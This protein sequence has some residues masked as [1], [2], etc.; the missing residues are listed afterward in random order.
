MT[1]NKF[2]EYLGPFTLAKLAEIADAKII[3]CSAEEAE[4]VQIEN[5]KSI[6]QASENDIS[7]ITNKKYLKEIG[8]SKA[9]AIIAPNE[10]V[11]R[12][13]EGRIFLVSDD[14][15]YTYATMLSAFYKEPEI[16]KEI[17]ETAVID[18]T[19]KVGQNCFIGAGVVIKENA[20]IADNCVILENSVIG[21]SVTIGEGS[22]IGMCCSLAHCEVGKRVVLSSGVRIGETGFGFV[23]TSKGLIDVPQISKV[24]IEDDVRI[25]AN[26]TIDR[27]SVL[28]T[29]IG[30]SCRIDNL[31]QIGHNV[32]LG[33][34]CVLCGQVGLA[35]SVKTGSGVLMG[36]Q[37]GIADNVNI[38]SNVKILAQ[39]GVMKNIPDNSDM[40]G[41]PATSK[42]EFFKE[43]LLIK[44][45]ARKNR[46]A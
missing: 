5:V 32:S 33:K 12:L 8:S 23:I 17:H 13:P 2:F 42:N 30:E 34:G 9:K 19:A 10:L 16:A 45:M 38:G 18:R 6:D 44:R 29:V 27:G 11:S 24:V 41:S 39:S 37:V 15:H 28:D 21:A 4:L 25:G 40:M 14:P 1:Q 31:V 35:G 3:G 43:H 36:G 26:T 22:K 7:F 46:N 20:Q